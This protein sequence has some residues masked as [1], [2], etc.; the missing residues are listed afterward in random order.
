VISPKEAM[1]V[2]LQVDLFARDVL[3]LSAQK[4]AH[5]PEVAV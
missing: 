3:S 4:L 5:A 1:I 2:R